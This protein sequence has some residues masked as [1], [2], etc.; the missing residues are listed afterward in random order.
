MPFRRCS[1]RSL[2]RLLFRIHITTRE[3]TICRRSV[4]QSARSRISAKRF[5]MSSARATN[6]V[7][8]DVIECRVDANIVR[9]G[10]LTSP[11]PCPS[12][13]QFPQL[14]TRRGTPR[15]PTITSQLRHQHLNEA[16]DGRSRS[17]ISTTYRTESIYYRHV[18]GRIT[19]LPAAIDT[20]L[21]QWTQSFHCVQFCTCYNNL[22]SLRWCCT[23]KVSCR[24]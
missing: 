4:R 3:A 15:A 16:G 21:P 7:N 8:D 24:Q 6:A 2:F 22:I 13:S 12:C 9:R 1:V 5:V 17:A 11:R 10:H 19:F 14:S 18:T 23:V 20:A